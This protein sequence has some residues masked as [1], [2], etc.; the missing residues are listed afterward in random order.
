MSK[1]DDM[2]LSLMTFSGKDPVSGRPGGKTA[3]RA[4]NAGFGVTRIHCEFVRMGVFFINREKFILR[5][6]LT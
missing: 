4:G 6:W 3:V 1:L 2:S 5:N